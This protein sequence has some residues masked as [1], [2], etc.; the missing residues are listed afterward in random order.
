MSRST[1]AR[2]LSGPPPRSPD[3]APS[4]P[5]ARADSVPAHTLDLPTV[6]HPALGL[7]PRD[8]RAGWPTAADRLRTAAGEV[9]LRTLDIALARAPELRERVGEVGLRTLYRDTEI[10]VELLAR[11]VSS[12]DPDILRQWAEWVVPVY[13]RRRI[14]MD[15]L[16]VLLEATRTAAAAFLEAEARAAAD[17]ALDEAKQVFRHHRRLGGDA[18]PRNRLLAAIYKGA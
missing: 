17:R 4:R 11:V 15:D 9:R 14:A 10:L 6:S 16:I 7:P 3:P 5:P 1:S 8:M 13:R 2:E 18:R 12:N